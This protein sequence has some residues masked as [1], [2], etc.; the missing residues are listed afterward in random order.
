MGVTLI[1]AVIHIPRQ[2]S[3]KIIP[4]LKAKFLADRVIHEI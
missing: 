1:V 4:A 3:D 2:N